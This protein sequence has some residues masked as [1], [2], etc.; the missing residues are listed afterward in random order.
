MNNSS[1]TISKSS[2]GQNIR[3]FDPEFCTIT[4]SSLR[5]NIYLKKNFVLRGARCVYE[6]KIDVGEAKKTWCTMIALA[7]SQG[8][9]A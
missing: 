8:R 9:H 4:K 3:V 1:K 7:P 6:Y 5:K 2:G